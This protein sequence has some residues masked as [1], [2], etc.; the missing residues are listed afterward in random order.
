M[1]EIGHASHFWL[2]FVIS[3]KYGI[4]LQGGGAE[5]VKMQNRTQPVGE[6]VISSH[7]HSSMK[8]RSWLLNSVML[9]RLS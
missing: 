7:K 3:S 6:I 9:I 8:Q 1:I 2:V 5:Q 4:S